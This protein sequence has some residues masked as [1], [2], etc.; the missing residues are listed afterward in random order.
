MCCGLL[1]CIHKQPES[2]AYIPL[3]CTLSSH[4]EPGAV[5]LAEHLFPF[6]SLL[7]LYKCTHYPLPS[8][9]SSL[10][11]VPCVRV[12]LVF[13]VL[14]Q[15]WC[16]VWCGVT[17]SVPPSCCVQEGSLSARETNIRQ[18]LSQQCSW[19]DDEDLTDEPSEHW[20]QVGR[21]R[22]EGRRGDGRAEGKGRKKRGG[23]REL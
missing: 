14:V 3:H 9:A 11:S 1:G 16:T 17:L 18:A 6:T 8:T 5:A 7:Q 22:G 23:G 19:N 21:G 2:C 15:A 10:P 12:H 20:L 13:G 4:S